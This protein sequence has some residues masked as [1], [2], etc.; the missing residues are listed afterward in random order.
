[1]HSS[2]LGAG[3]GSISA[4]LALAACSND[5]RIER[6]DGGNGT[7]GDVGEGG[8]S[9]VT[10]TTGTGATGG[11]IGEPSDVYPAP[12]PDPPVVENLG[13]PI[14]TAPVIV[15]VY[16]STDD[17]ALLGGVSSFIDQ[18]GSTQYWKATTSEY[19]VGPASSLP[20]ITLTEAA[21]NVIDDSQVAAWLAAKLNANDPAFPTP[22]VNT[23]F[24]IYYPAGT[25]ITMNDLGGGT[26]CQ[27]FGAYH[28]STTLDAAH[29]NAAVPYAVMPRCGDWGQFS[30]ADA[31]TIPSSHEFI[32]AA[33]D[34]LP[35]SV[36]AYGQPDADNL[37]WAFILGGET[38]DLCA[39]SYSSYTKFPGDIDFAVARSWS[40]ASA[41]AGHN[42]CVP[43]IPGEVY[44]NAAPVMT[45]GIDLGGGMKSKG[46]RIAQGESRTIE[47][48][49]FSDGPTP[50]FDVYP[51]DMTSILG[52]G[53]S[54][55]LE[56][57]EYAGQNGQILHLTITVNQAS[58]YGLE[59]FMIRASQGNQENIWLG[60]VGN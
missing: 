43:L 39:Q 14:M 13:G 36:P 18:V 50:P 25:V 10:V 60:L 4:L 22:S 32:E 21:P 5:V 55:G 16:F 47:L 33:T 2:R 41:L 19:G 53:G 20:A 24:A 12:H 27:D 58:D 54:L 52:A 46:V 31:L 29:G 1:M 15:P 45:D 57:D 34:P 30:G 42:P 51:E 48:K 38:T 26:S 59:F 17:M 56:L 28:S 49:L 23:L 37:F 40:N 9:V 6:G 8:G 7:G 35:L 44:F 3:L 11:G